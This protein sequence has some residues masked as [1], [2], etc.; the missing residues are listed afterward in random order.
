MVVYWHVR[1]KL[2]GSCL[3]IG[4]TRRC[5]YRVYMSGID[6]T[7]GAAIVKGTGI[8]LGRNHS[9]ELA[10]PEDL[11]RPADIVSIIRNL[12]KATFD[13]MTVKPRKEGYGDREDFIDK[14]KRYS[15]YVYCWTRYWLKKPE[16]IWPEPLKELVRRMGRYPDRGRRE[17][18]KS[19]IITAYIMER[20]FGKERKK[21]G[22][23]QWTRDP[24]AFG[25]K[26]ISNNKYAKF[27][28]TICSS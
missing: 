5:D 15:A 9:I 6:L 28:R 19:R 22:L 8:G 18:S 26:F 27:V 3:S 11:A 13:Y 10:K 2:L 14:V 17:G 4:P 24:E 23:R 1:I 20:D 21:F 7:G 16:D 12:S 25:R